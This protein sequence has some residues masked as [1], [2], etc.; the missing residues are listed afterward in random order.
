[1]A[2]AGVATLFRRSST[3]AAMCPP[4]RSRIFP[5]C[6]GTPDG[7]TSLPSLRRMFPPSRA[8]LDLLAHRLLGLR[9][10]LGLPEGPRD[11]EG[12]EVPQGDVGEDLE[13]RADDGQYTSPAFLE[14]RDE[15]DVEVLAR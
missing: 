2:S 5:A 8:L 1:I 11:D 15:D 4:S 12:D 9:V 10:H 14:S 7:S 6:S 3:R 13:R